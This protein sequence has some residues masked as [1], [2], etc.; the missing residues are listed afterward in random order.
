MLKSLEKK[1]DS[2]HVEFAEMLRSVI[3]LVDRRFNL[4]ENHLGAVQIGVEKAKVELRQQIDGLGMRIDDLS[5][6]RAKYSDIEI[7]QKEIAD[8]R[9]RLDIT[10]RAKR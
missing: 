6:N 5:S 1:I 8:I 4:L 2:S 7:L 10:T 3:E 9:K